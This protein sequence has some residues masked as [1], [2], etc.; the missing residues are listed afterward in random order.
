MREDHVDRMGVVGIAHEQIAT[1][2][3]GVG[4]QC[5]VETGTGHVDLSRDLRAGQIHV[6]EAGSV[7]GVGSHEQIA[8]D[9]QVVGV[10]RA[11]ETGAAHA[12]ISRDL[13]AAQIHF[14]EVGFVLVNGSLARLPPT[15]SKLAVSVPSKLAPI[16]PLVP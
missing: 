5:A 8:P 4:V 3:Q 6:L 14:L 1:G 11:V 10:Q 12:H 2:L 13:R 16:M 7:L 15:S 9:L